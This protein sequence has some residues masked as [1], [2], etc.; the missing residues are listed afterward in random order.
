MT[1]DI[2]V[3]GDGTIKLTGR[4]DSSQDDMTKEILG[5]VE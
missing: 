4:L 3:G 1:F 2:S 5:R